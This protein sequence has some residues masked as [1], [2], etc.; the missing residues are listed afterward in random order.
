MNGL[1]PLA[2]A[3]C[4]T[5]SSLISPAHGH[6]MPWRDGESRQLGFG[7]CSKGPCMKRTCWAPSRPHRHVNGTI[8]VDRHGGPTCWGGK[9]RP[10]AWR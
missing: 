6:V 4:L 3:A 7:Q 9:L 10:Q 2:C 8:V 5:V 1:V